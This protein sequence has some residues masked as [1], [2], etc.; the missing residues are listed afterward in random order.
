MLPLKNS[1]RDWGDDISPDKPELSGSLGILMKGQKIVEVPNRNGFVYVRLRNNTSELIQAFNDQVSPVYNLGV[2]LVRDGNRYKVVGRDIQRYN[3]W[4]SQSSFI[5]RHANQHSFNPDFGGGGDVVWIYPR[6]FMP[7][8]VIPSGTLGSPNVIVSAY[9]Q[10]LDDGSWRYEGETGTAD[11]TPIYNPTNNNAVMALI[12]KDSAGNP[13]FIINS[14]TYFD[15]SITGTKQIT[16]FIPALSDTSLIPLSAIRLISGSSNLVWDNIYDVRQFS[17]HAVNPLDEGIAVQDEGVFVGTGTTLNFVGVNVDASVSGTV[18]R[19]FITGSVGGGDDETYLRLDAANDPISGRLEIVTSGPF[20]SPT[21]ATLKLFAS[22][23]NE[24]A[25]QAISNHGG[26]IYA[27]S[28]GDGGQI[29]G[30]FE[31][32]PSGTTVTQGVMFLYREPGGGAPNF[33]SP[34]IDARESAGAGALYG[35]ILRGKI[36]GTTRVFLNP[37]ATGTLS[38]YLFDTAGERPSGTIASFQHNG[39]ELVSISKS[40]RVTITGNEDTEQFIIKANDVQNKNLQEWQDSTDEKG[41]VIGPDAKELRF[42][43][44]GESNYVGF[45]APALT[46]NQL[47]A[48]PDVDGNANE[49]LQTDGAGNLI[50]APAGADAT[51]IEIYDDGEF[52][53]SGTKLSFDNNLNLGLSGT[54]IHIESPITTYQRSA[55]PS[56]ETSPSGSVW[57]V[58]DNV[59]ASGSLAVFYNGLIQHKGID[60]E[61]LVYVSGTFQYLFTPATGS[62]H[63]A[64]YGVPCISQAFISGTPESYLQ[65]SDSVLLQDSDSEQLLDSDG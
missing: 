65:D 27:Q 41:V 11:L 59:Y 12:Y 10:Q 16:Q 1:F 29:V 22:G 60:Y 26:A 47:W 28:N 49:F 13:G 6:Q 33:L 50:F 34:M 64:T 52:F 7:S 36:G 19:I 42:Y 30:D 38:N 8:L 39:T 24:G 48:L 32:Y 14:G 43:D 25:L 61:E 63:M 3:D 57:K 4:G 51:I 18:A 17:L 31:H 46:A 5:P 45:K 62:S 55:I 23:T 54:V 35:G 2:L 15:N 37:T 21:P 20:T 40:G 56:P 53:A 9:T 58:P 44:I